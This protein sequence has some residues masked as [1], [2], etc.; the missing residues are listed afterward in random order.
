MSKS[1]KKNSDDY[2]LY[3]MCQAF[4]SKGIS[5]CNANLIKKE[6]IEQKVL[7]QI[8]YLVN[9][10][11]ILNGL[12]KELNKDSSKENEVLTRDVD[13][14]KAHLKKVINK[15]S[16][17]DNDYFEGELNSGI[18]NRLM[19]DVQKEI[20]QLERTIR[21][22]E[23]EISE[24]KAAIDKE[25]VIYILKHFNE[26]FEK[27]NNEEKKL[28]MRSLIKEI[29]M[30]ENRKDIEKM[31]FWFSPVL[32]LPSN[33]ERGAKIYLKRKFVTLRIKEQPFF[34]PLIR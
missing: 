19:V 14:F 6:V 29:R 9:N 28:L 22:S 4:H 2:Y 21:K 27:V 34:S 31:T 20:E 1:K 26:F 30:N 24:N 11:N 8:S 32:S 5:V 18:Y 15:R 3:Y 23:D 12:I 16:K 17:L 33:K 7:D 13:K 10:D 25:Q